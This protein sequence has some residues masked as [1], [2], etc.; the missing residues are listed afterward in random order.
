MSAEA[1]DAVNQPISIVRLDLQH[2]GTSDIFLIRTRTGGRILKIPRSIEGQANEVKKDEQREVEFPKECIAAT[3]KMPA[4]KAKE[5][6]GMQ[7]TPDIEEALDKDPICLLQ[8]SIQ[9]RTLDAISES[10]LVEILLENTEI[11][12]DI[13]EIIDAALSEFIVNTLHGRL[14]MP[15]LWGYSEKPDEE[16]PEKP[17]GHV[18][19]HRNRHSLDIAHST[20]IMVTDK[21]E[22]GKRAAVLVDIEKTPTKGRSLLKKLIWLAAAPWHIFYLLKMQKLIRKTIT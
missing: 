21:D 8:E 1:L 18:L 6:L 4:S 9:G 10:E 14:S 20:N 13:L 22:E 19:G 11:G 16:I 3:D 12:R 17:M 2:N 5:I 7:V 15:D